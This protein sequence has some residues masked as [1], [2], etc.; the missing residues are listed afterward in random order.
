MKKIIFFC[1]ALLSQFAVQLQAQNKQFKDIVYLYDGSRLT[2]NVLSY[3][4]DESILL[5]LSSGQQLI[6]LAKNVKK[7]VM[8]MPSIEKVNEPYEF[9]ERGLYNASSF[10]LSFGKSTFSNAVGVGF[11]H[12][13]GYQMSR[14]LGA[15]VGMS[16]EN[17]YLQNSAEGRIF[18]VFG[19]IRGYLSKHN[20]AFYYNLA[21]GMAFPV[22]KASENLTGH[23]GGLLVYPAFGMRFGASKRYNFFMDIGAKIQNVSY[24]ALNEWQQDYYTVTYR[25]WVL[26]GGILF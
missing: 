6:F 25:R 4:P 14:L 11:Q 18:S 23:K 7:V 10:S 13:V 19:E 3:K 21:G 20:T 15:G 2:G 26:R 12:S 17:L 16:Y 1:I 5:E 24:N 8:S 22:A 9:K